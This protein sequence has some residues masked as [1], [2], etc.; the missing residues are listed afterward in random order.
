MQ[1]S[2]EVA[3]RDIIILKES[4]K[5]TKEIKEKSERLH[6]QE[7][8]E[9]KFK[10]LKQL[11]EN[12]DLK[13]KIKNLNSQISIKNVHPV[14]TLDKRDPL[15]ITLNTQNLGYLPKNKF[16]LSNNDSYKGNFRFLNF[17]DTILP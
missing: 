14:Q 17:R 10:N 12:T 4:L 13:E 5:D 15:F 6:S 2:F 11:K 1:H 9:L 8:T 3:K 7:T 16:V